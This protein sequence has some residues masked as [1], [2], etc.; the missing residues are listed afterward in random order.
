MDEWC[1]QGPSH[2]I[3]LGIGDHTAALETFAEAVSFSLY[4]FDPV[5]SSASDRVRGVKP[6]PSEVEERSRNQMLSTGF[7]IRVALA[8][9]I[10]QTEAW[11]P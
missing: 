2:H 10:E 11:Q 6:A 5:S 9:R 4:E 8:T 7:S 3:A 1:Q